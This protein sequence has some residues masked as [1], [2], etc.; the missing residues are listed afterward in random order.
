MQF[1]G[2]SKLRSLAKTQMKTKTQKLQI[3][4]VSGQNVSSFWLPETKHFSFFASWMKTSELLQ[5]NVKISF[6]FHRTSSIGTETISAFS[7]FSPWLDVVWLC[8]CG[9]SLLSST[10]PSTWAAALSLPALIP[11]ALAACPFLAVCGQ[12]W[13]SSAKHFGPSASRDVRS[14]WGW[15]MH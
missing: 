9:G 5:K 8:D 1:F 4:L 2:I 11:P 3:V 13:A 6:C 7:L 10:C 15:Q 14:I 12:V